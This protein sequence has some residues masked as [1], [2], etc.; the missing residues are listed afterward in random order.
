MVVN[1]QPEI[2]QATLSDR[3]GGITNYNYDNN[4]NMTSIIDPQGQMISLNDPQDRLMQ[5][6]AIPIWRN[7]PKASLM[8]RWAI[9]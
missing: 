1:D 6:T 3:D 7:P 2:N 9:V 4:G 5:N 8:T